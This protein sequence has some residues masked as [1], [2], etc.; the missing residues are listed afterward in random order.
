M[1]PSDGRSR[2]CGALEQKW[3]FSVGLCWA[4]RGWAFM[5]TLIIGPGSPWDVALDEVT[6]H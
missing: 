5:S 2:P 6:L 3:S 4:R 1:Q